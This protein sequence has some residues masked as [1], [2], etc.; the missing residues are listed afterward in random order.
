MAGRAIDIFGFLLLLWSTTRGLGN[1][2]KE[3]VEEQHGCGRP[4]VKARQNMLV[5][6]R[7]RKNVFDIN[8]TL[9]PPSSS[10]QE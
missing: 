5:E 10:L 3:N 7:S 4:Y 6:K 1:K 8:W 2:K 9:L